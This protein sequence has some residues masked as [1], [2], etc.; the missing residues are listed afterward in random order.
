M[1][2]IALILLFLSSEAQSAT[3]TAASLSQSD[4]QTAITASSAGDTVL[5]PSGTMS[6][7]PDS[8]IIISKAISIIGAGQGY[9][10]SVQGALPGLTK[11]VAGTRTQQFF[12][13]SAIPLNSTPWGISHICFDASGC[14]ANAMVVVGGAFSQTNNNFRVHHLSITNILQNGAYTLGQTEGVIDHCYF[15]DYGN[16]SCHGIEVDG[17][18]R[19]GTEWTNSAN[20][21]ASWQLGHTNGFTYVE[22]CVFDFQYD[23]D[24]ACELYWDGHLCFR[25][26]FVTNSS[27]GVHENGTISRSATVWE[28]YNNYVSVTNTGLE[29]TVNFLVLRSGYGVV[30]SNTLFVAV[31][32]SYDPVFRLLIYAASGTN[33]Y[34][35]GAGNSDVTL[36]VGGPYNNTYSCGVGVTGIYP[37][38]GNS[39]SICL[40]YPHWDQPG[41]GDPSV[42]FSYGATVGSPGGGSSQTFY[43]LYSW[44][45]TFMGATWTNSVGYGPKDFSNGDSPQGSGNVGLISWRGAD[46]LPTT[47]QLEQPGR[48]Y[49]NDTIKP[50]YTPLVYPHPLAGGG[51]AT[52]S[53][54]IV[55]IL[56]SGHSEIRR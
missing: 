54:A 37:V 47:T 15:R 40:G 23:N 43:G 49:F 16:F 48:D 5:L 38:D 25:Y 34:G 26:N 8:P 33:V 20:A 36:C 7:W 42:W 50:G 19:T 13:F 14:S 39:N 4:I 29:G 18:Q 31:S 32:N 21:T 35:F 51:V 44:S 53:L 1:R 10:G 28:Y 56:R 30:F 11:F 46:W 41:Y 45:N 52:N 24:A 17:F 22:D 27:C 9:C 2:I 55:T 6:A 3:N 12:R